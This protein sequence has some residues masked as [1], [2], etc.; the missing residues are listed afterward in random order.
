MCVYLLHIYGVY[1]SLH[2]GLKSS[3]YYLLSE[4]ALCICNVSDQASKDPIWLSLD[5]SRDGCPSLRWT[6]RHAVLAIFT[7]GIALYIDICVY[8]IHITYT[9]KCIH[10]YARPLQRTCTQCFYKLASNVYR[11]QPLHTP[12]ET[13][14]IASRRFNRPLSILPLVARSFLPD[15]IL[16]T[17]WQCRVS[18]GWLRGMRYLPNYMTYNVFHTHAYIS[19][20]YM[21]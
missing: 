6:V 5:I 16:Y 12:W 4:V 20:I 13:E 1:T 21:K 10:I 11:C 17:G 18:Y 14:H 2:N 19:H 3:R 9:W 15:T 8:I 7:M